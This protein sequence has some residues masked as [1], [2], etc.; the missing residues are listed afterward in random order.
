MTENL[1]VLILNKHVLLPYQE[2]KLDFHEDKTKD[3]INYACDEYNKKVL[4]IFSSLDNTDND[5]P[6]VGVIGKISK[7]LVLSNGNLRV[8]INGLNRVQVKSY[9]N[10]NSILMSSFKKLYISN[11]VT[12]EEEANL[13]RLKN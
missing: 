5:F 4:V 2:L 3:I 12:L 6:K 8:I 7:K 10:N 1:P 9:E 11:P 13:K